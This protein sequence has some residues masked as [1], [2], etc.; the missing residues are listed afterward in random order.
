MQNW[1]KS[2]GT[3]RLNTK[4]KERSPDLIGRVTIHCHLIHALLKQLDESARDVAECNIA[5]WQY[6]DKD[7]PFLNLQLSERYEAPRRDQGSE[8][9]LTCCQSAVIRTNA[10]EIDRRRATRSPSCIPLAIV[11]ATIGGY[12]LSQA[13][14][15][16][17]TAIPT[18]RGKVP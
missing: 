16:A 11:D 10:I 1:T 8:T 15:Y 6:R 14:Y 7:G 12:N 9:I 5:A 3:L 4:T 13:G 2:M 18:M 17:I